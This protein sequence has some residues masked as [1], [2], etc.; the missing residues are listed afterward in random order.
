MDQFVIV[1]I[2]SF[3]LTIRIAVRH[4]ILYLSFID[5]V[6]SFTSEV[7][8]IFSLRVKFVCFSFVES[9]DKKIAE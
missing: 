1:T 7:S 2:L 4:V 9:F 3:G 5:S 8:A 6:D